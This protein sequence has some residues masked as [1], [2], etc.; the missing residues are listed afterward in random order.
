MGLMGDDQAYLDK[1]LEELRLR[2]YSRQTERAYLYLIRKFIRSG[3]QPREFLLGYTEKSRSSIRSAYFA[4]KFFYGNILGQKFDENIPLARSRGKLPL[5]LSKEEVNGMLETT[6][7]LRH[8]LVLMSLYY[9]GI[10]LSELVNLEWEDIDFKRDIIH[11]KTAKGGKERIIFLH[12]KL[13]EF[14]EYFN[15]KREGLALVSNLGRKY[16]KR[17]IQMI[18]KNAAKRAGIRKRVTPHTFRHSF[19]THLLEAGADIR[20]IQKLLG[21]SNLQTTQIY[22]HVANR[23]IKKLADLL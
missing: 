4:L 22:T 8:R 16:N 14:I 1:L 17:S 10:R 20:H 21:H 15:L 19:A 12:G 23:D 11:L 13:K 9:T 7:N 2:K 5:V 18:V 6:L 3:L